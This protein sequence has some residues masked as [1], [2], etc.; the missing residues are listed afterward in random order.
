MGEYRPIPPS[1]PLS[2]YRA[3]EFQLQC[4]RCRRNAPEVKTYKMT[5]RFG[6]GITF[7]DLVRQLAGS[8]P[9]PCGLASSGQ[10]AAAAWEPPVEHWAT[11]DQALRGRWL[12]RV[13]CMR[14]TAAL[15]RVDPCPEV[16][17]LDI[18][19]LHVAYGHDYPLSRLRMRCRHCNSS[20]TAIEWI[21]PP[22]TPDPYSPVSA[23]APVL[24]L[25]PTRAQL[26]RRKFRII[27]G[28][29]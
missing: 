14:H 13:H 24:Q 21:V 17:I 18:E 15:K 12:A 8:G 6:S 25:K 11:L 2:A 29:E 10:C 19:T 4:A 20:V 7:A 28:E 22:V 16:T 3:P 23:E 27:G 26:G 1:T 9:K 5:R